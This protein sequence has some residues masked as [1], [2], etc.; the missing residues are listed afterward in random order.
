[1]PSRRTILFSL[2]CLAALGFVAEGAWATIHNQKSYKQA[3]PGKDPTTYSCNVCHQGAVGK[4]SDLNGYGK[5]L[6]ALPAP[7]NPKKLTLEDY[8]AAEAAD[9][10]GDGV[11]TWQELEAGTDPSDAASVPPPVAGITPQTGA[12]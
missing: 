12:P 6:K 9:P 10:D 8:T 4:A 5:A 11:T 3:Y 1:M 2:S 7:T